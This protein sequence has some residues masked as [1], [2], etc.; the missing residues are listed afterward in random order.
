MKK[1]RTFEVSEDIQ[2]LKGT[3]NMRLDEDDTSIFK[4][5]RELGFN[6]NK[7][8]NKIIW[9]DDDYVEIINKRTEL[10]VGIMEMCYN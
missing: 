5:L 10:T 3:I 1:Y 6:T 9:W 8:K 7:R 2:H 4:K